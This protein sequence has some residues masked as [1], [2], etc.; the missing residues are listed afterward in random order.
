MAFVSIFVIGAR[1]G[2]NAFMQADAKYR[3]S[4]AV[5]RLQALN[6]GKIDYVKDALY[7]DI[8]SALLNHVEGARNPLI[9]LWPELNPTN[10][11]AIKHVARYI[12]S[13]PHSIKIDDLSDSI[14]KDDL[15]K[16]KNDQK[17]IDSLIYS[18]SQ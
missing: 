7:F 18:Y 9:Y 2:A 10:D 1:V 12:Y 14:S 6:E 13:H 17:I 4:L 8:D 5:Y 16:I 3:A 15:K 11:D